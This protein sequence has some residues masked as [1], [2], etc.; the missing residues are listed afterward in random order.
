MNKTA[1]FLAGF[2]SCWGSLINPD[3]TLVG[4]LGFEIYENLQYF[5]KKDWAVQETLEFM[6]GFYI[7]IILLLIYW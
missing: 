1:H 6:T 5:K 3:I 2:L 7:G 4:F